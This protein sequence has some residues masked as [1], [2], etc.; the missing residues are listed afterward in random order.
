M[1]KNKTRHGG[2]AGVIH[3]RRY[4]KKWKGVARRVKL[5]D[6]GNKTNLKHPFNKK[7]ANFKFIFEKT[8]DDDD[9]DDDNYNK[10]YFESG[11]EESLSNETFV[12]MMQGQR[13]VCQSMAYVRVLVRCIVCACPELFSR[14]SRNDK[15]CRE[16]D[17]QLDTNPHHIFATKKHKCKGGVLRRLLLQAYLNFVADRNYAYSLTNK[18]GVSDPKY[19][20][21]LWNHVRGDRTYKR[22]LAHF[23]PVKKLESHSI[24]Q[25][26]IVFSILDIFNFKLDEFERK[27]KQPA[28]IPLAITT[29]PFSVDLFLFLQDL[30]KISICNGQNLYIGVG[31]TGNITNNLQLLDTPHRSKEE[32]MKKTRLAPTTTT[33]TTTGN[34]G[35]RIVIV[36]VVY[37]DDAAPYLKCVNTHKFS[38]FV[39]ITEAVINAFPNC[40]RTLSFLAVNEK[41]ESIGAE[42][43]LS[44]RKIP[45]SIKTIYKRKPLSRRMTTMV[46]GAPTASYKPY[47]RLLLMF[48][49]QN[50]ETLIGNQ[51]IEIDGYIRFPSSFYELQTFF[52]WKKDKTDAT[53]YRSLVEH[54]LKTCFFIFFFEKRKIALGDYERG[55]EEDNDGGGGAEEIFE[56]DDISEIEGSDKDDDDDDEDTNIIDEDID[57]T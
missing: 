39:Y 36:D 4:T 26:Q 25:L 33:T 2:A 7:G 32:I 55:V 38:K 11:E 13:P 46:V 28:I 30:F 3:A 34:R 29:L 6:D 1:P 8:D 51:Y 44:S 42:I 17:K 22:Y 9:D 43:E 53:K 27:Y 40:L 21:M 37:T 24:E 52:F 19:E 23:I 50:L 56:D 18:S 35:H 5:T 12:N 48:L 41:F 45:K 57:K 14:N 54:F 49:R 15:S 47:S 10:E 31:L 16:L 20:V